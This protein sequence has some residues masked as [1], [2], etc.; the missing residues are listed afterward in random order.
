MWRLCC[1]DHTYFTIY[2]FAIFVIAVIRFI[3]ITT[4]HHHSYY[5]VLMLLFIISVLKHPASTQTF[6]D[7][8]MRACLFTF[9]RLF[10]FPSCLTAQFTQPPSC[11]APIRSRTLSFECLDNPLSWGNSFL[12]GKLCGSAGSGQVWMAIPRY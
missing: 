9:P 4:L 5:I 10:T 8:G 6:G 2:H 11:I 7:L 12:P 1:C 3:L